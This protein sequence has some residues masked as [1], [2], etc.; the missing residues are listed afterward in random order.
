MTDNPGRAPTR[1]LCTQYVGIIQEYE[2]RFDFH[3]VEVYM[4]SNQ[5]RGIWSS[6]VLVASGRLSNKMTKK[7]QITTQPKPLLHDHHQQKNV[8]GKALN[9][10]HQVQDVSSMYFYHS[11]LSLAVLRTLFLLDIFDYSDLCLVGLFIAWI[12]TSRAEK[13]QCCSN[14]VK[15]PGILGRFPHHSEQAQRKKNQPTQKQ[16]NDRVVSFRR[17]KKQ[18]TE[19]STR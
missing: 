18:Q 9:N 10:I 6:F 8:T 19:L 2:Y 4:Y 15:Q 3:R 12:R 1:S 5:K 13:S 14:Y 11:W 16:E 17:K 7:L